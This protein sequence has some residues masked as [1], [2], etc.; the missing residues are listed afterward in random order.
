MEGSARRREDP[1]C[2]RRC[3]WRVASTADMTLMCCDV[4]DACRP[5]LRQKGS[6]IRVPSAAGGVTIASVSPNT[7]SVDVD[8]QS[9][10]TE[11]S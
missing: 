10:S 11:S 5:P 7:Q 6:V 3:M 1:A 8:C 4:F 9:W 2:K